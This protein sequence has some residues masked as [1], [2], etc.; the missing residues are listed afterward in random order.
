GFRRTP[1]G[2][3]EYQYRGPSSCNSETT[4]GVRLQPNFSWVKGT[5]S[6][7]GGLDMRL[8]WYT[9]EINTTLFV[10]TF[11]R[12]LTQRVFN[13]SE[14]LSGNSI[15]SFLLGA[16]AFGAIENNFYPTFRWNYY[17]PWVQ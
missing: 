16:P 5:H 9:R 4:T 2:T 13:A 6:V 1:T 11:D 12:R 14:A 17:A 8:T 3:T 10:L 7:R 15:A